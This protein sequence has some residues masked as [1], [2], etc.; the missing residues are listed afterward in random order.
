MNDPMFN[1]FNGEINQHREYT[2]SD[3]QKMKSFWD[4][5]IM[6]EDRRG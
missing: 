2:H 5:G 4:N 3:N 6:A 1:L